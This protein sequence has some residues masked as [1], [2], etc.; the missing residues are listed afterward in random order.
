MARQGDARHHC[1]HQRKGRSAY[2][3]TRS[4]SAAHLFGNPASVAA[5]ISKIWDSIG[6][7]EGEEGPAELP[8]GVGVRQRPDRLDWWS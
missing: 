3:P 2:D 1:R 5:L 7:A 8:S 4:E 6:H